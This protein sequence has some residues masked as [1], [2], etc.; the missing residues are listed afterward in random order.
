M[1]LLVFGDSIGEGLYDLKKGGWTNR[2]KI[3]LRRKGIYLGNCS[4]SGFT[5]NDVLSFFENF[6]SSFTKKE[7]KNDTAIIIAIGTNDSMIYNKKEN[8]TKEIFETN[9]KEIITLCKNYNFIKNIFFISTTNCDEE[10][11]NPVLWGKFY[12]SNKNLETY[13]EIIKRISKENDLY[14][15]DIYGLLDKT[16]FY[17]GLHPNQNGHKKIYKKVYNYIKNKI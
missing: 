16:D 17:D 15:I 9:L 10:K 7:E 11:T 14:F 6:V 2:L 3:K 13:N 4:I 8:T 1:R 12:Y 5:S